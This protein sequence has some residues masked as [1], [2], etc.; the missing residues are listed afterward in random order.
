VE[1]TGWAGSLVAAEVEHCFDELLVR[2]KK[3]T[4]AI[5]KVGGSIQ[6]R[7]GCWLRGPLATL[8]LDDIS[9]LVKRGCLHS[10]WNCSIFVREDEVLAECISSS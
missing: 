6:T 9:V 5:S 2:G 10:R 4:G 7:A 1:V 3:M 8:W